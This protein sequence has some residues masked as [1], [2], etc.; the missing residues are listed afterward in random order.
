[1]VDLT[2]RLFC[3]TGSIDSYLLLREMEKDQPDPEPEQGSTE[4]RDLTN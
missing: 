4:T 2:W 1:M 3:M